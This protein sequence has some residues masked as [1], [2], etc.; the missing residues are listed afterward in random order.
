MKLAEGLQWASAVQPELE[1][2]S[3]FETS[4]TV[5][6]Q[7]STMDRCRVEREIGQQS[8]VKVDIKYGRSDATGLER[9]R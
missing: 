2:V 1:V 7:Q 5:G 9:E 6:R 8:K 3:S 4:E